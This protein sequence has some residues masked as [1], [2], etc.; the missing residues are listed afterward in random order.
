MRSFCVLLLCLAAGMTALA[1]EGP[2]VAEETAAPAV[3][4]DVSPAHAAAEAFFA[5][6]KANDVDKAFDDLL[7]GSRIAEVPKDVAMLKSKTREAIKLTGAIAGADLCEQKAVGNHLLKLVY[8]SLGRNFPLRWRF[9]FY[10]TGDGWKL[11][12]IRISDSLR[13]MFR[14]EEEQT[15]P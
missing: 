15:A 14:E 7:K 2:S 5:A 9:Y 8:I 11:I 4:G 6:L 10:K 1:Q 3:S 12:D 13:E